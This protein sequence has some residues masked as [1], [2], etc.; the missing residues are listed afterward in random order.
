V[1]RQGKPKLVI[2]GERTVYIFTEVTGKKLRQST[3]SP[4]LGAATPQPIIMNF[5]PNCG[6]TDIINFTNFCFHQSN[7]KGTVYDY[8]VRYS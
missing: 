6:P 8:T 5:G 4:I 3:T 7:E 1:Q 2:V